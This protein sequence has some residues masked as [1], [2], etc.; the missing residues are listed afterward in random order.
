MN[1]GCLIGFG[2][3]LLIATIGLGTYFYQ[4]NTRE[5]EQV[6]TAQPVQADIIKKT[7][8]T[9]AIRPRK[10]VMI[11]PQVSGVVDEIYV[12][13]GQLVTKG[14]RLAR[15]K[16]V[17]SEV[18]INTA[19]SNVEL[20]RLRLQEAQRELERQQGLN[21]QQLDVEEARARY[22]NAR[23]EE[24]RQRQLYDDGVISQQAYNQFKLDFQLA[25]AAYENT[26]VVASNSIRQFETEVSIREQ[27]LEAAINNLQLLREGASSNSKQVAN[28]VT[29]TLDG[30]V[31]DLPVEEGTS[32][33]ERNNFN[34]GTSIAIVADM[35][36][37]IFEGKV[38]ESDVGKL[39]EGMPLLLTVGAIEDLEFDATLEFIS[40]KGED[41][42]GTVKFEVRAAVKPTEDVFLRAGY[43]ANADI[44]LDRRKEVLAI[45]ERDVLYEGDTAYVE[46]QVGERQFEKRQVELGLSD[47]IQVEVLKGLDGKSQ[48]KVQTKSVLGL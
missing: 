19:K 37:L 31:L 15:I 17:P 46:L 34:E 48:I 32:V 35:N 2:A 3:F 7:V 24:E 9:G 21:R 20:A 28:I 42:E 40:P 39:R 29:S 11:K 18:N 1:K 8:A 44:I 5:A 4:R 43:S 16:L 30:M 23:Q 26:K 41:E 38:D 36:A 45:Q 12:E 13:E 6:E 25:Q 33:I 14:Q 22:E 47:G 10:E 27:E